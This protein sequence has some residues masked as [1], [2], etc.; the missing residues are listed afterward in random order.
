MKNAET[1]K[2]VEKIY[3]TVY[4]ALTPVANF[5]PCQVHLNILVHI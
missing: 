5:A 2:C 3:R 1:I 4:L